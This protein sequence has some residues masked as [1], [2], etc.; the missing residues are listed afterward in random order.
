MSLRCDCLSIYVPF[1]I[2]SRVVGNIFGIT[3]LS[4]FLTVFLRKSERVRVTFSARHFSP[5]IPFVLESGLEPLT[6][7]VIH[8]AA[9]T[10]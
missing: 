2:T 6:C 5:V 3:G 1:S 9:L 8:R 10:N 4:A 7:P